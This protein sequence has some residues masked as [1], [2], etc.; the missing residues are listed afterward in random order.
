MAKPVPARFDGE[1][2]SFEAPELGVAPGQAAVLLCRRPRHGRRLD[3]GNGGGGRGV[4]GLA[5]AVR[6][7]RYDTVLDAPF[8]DVLEALKRPDTMVHVSRPLIH[9]RPRTPDSLPEQWRDGSYVVS[10][11]LFGVIPLG[12]QTIGIEF[13]DMD[14][15]EEFTGLDHGHS[16]LMKRWDHEIGIRKLDEE[17]TAYYDDVTIDAGLLAPFAAL[18]VR[19]L[20][21]HRQKRLRAYAADGFGIS[22]A[23]PP[24][25]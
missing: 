14:S 16:A 5:I 2:L 1:M 25:A 21:L 10:L 19:L 4:G 6:H 12:K 17:R 22:S 24:P 15:R 8:D 7:I 11:R 13:G 3:R 23:N 18:F 20:F 9:F